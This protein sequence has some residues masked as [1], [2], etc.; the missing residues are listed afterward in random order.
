MEIRNNEI[1]LCD[2]DKMVKCGNTCIIYNDSNGFESFIDFNKQDKITLETSGLI[3]YLTH[4]LHLTKYEDTVLLY[5]DDQWID[6][7]KYVQYVYS[8][9]NGYNGNIKST[10]ENVITAYCNNPLLTNE[11]KWN[12]PEY[13]EFNNGT[14][15]FITNKL[16]SKSYDKYQTIKIDC[17]YVEGATSEILDKTLDVILPDKRVQKSYLAYLGYVFYK[18]NLKLGKWAV[19]YGLTHTCKSTFGDILVRVLN[20]TGL[21]AIVQ[22]KDIG[23]KFD[24]KYYHNKLLLY[25][26]D[27][28]DGYIPDTGAWKSGA[29]GSIERIEGKGKDA[30]TSANRSFYKLI[31]NS[32][33]LLTTKEG[34][35]DDAMKRRT[36]VY[37]FN[38]QI[39]ETDV[40]YNPN[41]I[42]DLSTEEVVEALI[43]KCIQEFRCVL[44][45]GKF[46]ETEEMKGY[47]NKLVDCN[48]K[49]ELLIKE[50]NFDYIRCTDAYKVFKEEC[51]NRNMKPMS[52]DWFIDKVAVPVIANHFMG[53]KPKLVN[54]MTIDEALIIDSSS[55]DTEH[56]KKLGFEKFRSRLNGKIVYKIRRIEQMF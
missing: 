45:Q 51:T 24:A 23:G 33:K 15:S 50:L 21:V 35:F 12:K 30:F 16:E 6:A 41:L 40:R 52:Y 9:F 39:K 26:D 42:G 20:R 56:L 22:P 38:Q 37:P 44:V 4:E 17:D 46:D 3:Y 32:N 55:S 36:I 18:D 54:R 34:E 2:N 19:N 43:Y 7:I 13:I 25:C 5:K 53:G 1:K 14:Y 49:H 8:K 47:L 29:T 48:R 27:L 11:V 28:T 31:A 10:I